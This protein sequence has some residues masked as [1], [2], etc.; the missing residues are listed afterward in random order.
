MAVLSFSISIEVS[1]NCI[2]IILLCVLSL[3]IV[4]IH[5]S[6]F[7]VSDQIDHIVEL[8]CPSF[9]DD[10]N[11][12]SVEEEFPWTEGDTYA[13][14]EKFYEGMDEDTLMNLDNYLHRD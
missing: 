2:A 7:E 9:I 6:E 11:Y 12:F 4:R 13:L 3:L 5:W 8:G 1:D 10:T 14:W